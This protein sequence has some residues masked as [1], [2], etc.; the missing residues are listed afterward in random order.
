MFGILAATVRLR[1]AQVQPQI[2]GT[3]QTFRGGFR[4]TL[5]RILDKYVIVGFLNYFLLVL[6][7]FVIIF[8]VFTFFELLDDVISN[9]IP[10]LVVLNY[11]RYLLPQIVFYMIPMSVLVAVL[12][13]FGVLTRTSQIVAMKASGVSLYRLALSLMIVTLLIS[14]LSFAMQE[15]VLPGCNQKQDALRDII[16]GRRPQTYLR[17][18]RKCMMG[19]RSKIF[20]YNFF[21]EHRNLFGDLSVFEFD[22]ASFEIRRRIY[23]TRAHW[24]EV[25][26]TWILEDGWSQGFREQ[27]AVAKEFVRFERQRFPEIA[28]DP[29]YFKKEVKQSSQMSY[30]ELRN[31]IEDLRQSGFDVVRLTVALHKKLSFPIIS[32]IMCMIAITFSFSMGK[33][34]SLYGVGLSIMIGIT[35]WVMLEFFEQVGGA[36]KLLPF[37]AAWAPNLIFGA[38]G[39]YYLFTIRT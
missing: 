32:L 35:Y 22:P 33:R 12:V 30:L 7:S 20:Y 39:V 37:L 11:F 27:R 18:D 4:W 23:A 8:I 17:P 24:D 5:P 14:A 16:K 31:Y 15:Y 3:G 28:E 29:R 25:Q 26:G 38:S 1:P 9:Q 10:I 13:N 19:E 2:A 36:G 21:D 6:C 34:G